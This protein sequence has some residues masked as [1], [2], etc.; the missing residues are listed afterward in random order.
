MA[1]PSTERA[2]GTSDWGS[3][4]FGA[5]NEMPPEPVHGIGRVL[6]TMSTLPAFRDAREW[7]LR[8]LRISHSSSVIEAGCGNAAA[9]AGLLSTVGTKGRVVGIDPTKA[10][11]EEA[12]ARAE[13]LGRPT[14]GSRWVTFARFHR[15]MASS[16]LRFATRC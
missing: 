12:R 14:R 11:I 15:R 1:S 10:F 2:G 6:E 7:V 16:T 5:L 8:S 9:L 3:D 4:F 13:R